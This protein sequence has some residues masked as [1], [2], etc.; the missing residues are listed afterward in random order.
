[1]SACI[2]LMHFHHFIFI[3]CR[4]QRT[5]TMRLSSLMRLTMQFAMIQ[6]STGSARVS[7]NIGSFVDWLLLARNTAA[8]VAKVTRITRPG[9][10]AGRPGRGTRHC[11]FADIVEL[12][13][14]AD[15][16]CFLDFFIFFWCGTFWIL[17]R[18]SCLRS[19]RFC[20]VCLS[21]STFGMYSS[22]EV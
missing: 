12:V 18:L 14:L 13:C 22:L 4:I 9:H 19:C 6:G 3:S 7:T 16:W 21:C 11:P 8:S 17:F 20:F 15:G 5:N 10:L 2:I 1:M